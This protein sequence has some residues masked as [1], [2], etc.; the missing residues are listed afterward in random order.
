MPK[1]GMYVLQ[2]VDPAA[3]AV[4]PF[5]VKV[6]DLYSDNGQLFTA[7]QVR[8]MGGGAGNKLLLGYFSIG[9]AEDYRDYFKTIPPA[10]I[11]PVNPD[12]PGN[13][14]VAYWTSEWRTVATTYLDR[15]I[16]LGYDRLSLDVVDGS[17]QAWAARNVPG[18]DAAGAMVDLIKYLA[19]YA[20]AQ[21]ANFKIWANNAEELLNNAT[22]FKPSTV[23][24]RKSFSTRIMGPRNPQPTR[25]GASICCTRRLPRART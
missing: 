25:T 21:N 2:G 16:K 9:E 5:D 23:Y 20:H 8:Q 14:Q 11:G 22:Y 3:V 15:M 24:T 17:Q 12:W 4:A 7:A 19:D 6:I 18:G 1:T 10:A 13:F